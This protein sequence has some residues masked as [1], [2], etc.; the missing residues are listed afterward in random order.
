MEDKDAQ[1]L[2]AKDVLATPS[3]S[4]TAVLHTDRPNVVLVILEGMVAQ[5]FE[6]LGEKRR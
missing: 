2:I 1:A 6:D 3:D 4:I 5:V